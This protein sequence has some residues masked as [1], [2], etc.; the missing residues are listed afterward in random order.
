VLYLGCEA[1]AKEKF[2]RSRARLP[3][4]MEAFSKNDPPPPSCKA[5]QPKRSQ[6]FCVQLRDVHP[7]NVLFTKDKLP[8]GIILPS[9]AAAPSLNMSRPSA[10]TVPLA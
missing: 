2:K 4:L 7:N 10:K 5:L 9:V 1:N 3:A 8:D 6:P